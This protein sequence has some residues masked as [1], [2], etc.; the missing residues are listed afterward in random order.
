[1]RSGI[2]CALLFLPFYAGIIISAGPLLT[3][4][5]F[6]NGGQYLPSG[7]KAPDLLAAAKERLGSAISTS[8]PPGNFMASIVYL[9]CKLLMGTPLCRDE[10][11]LWRSISSSLDG[12]NY[13]AN[14][15]LGGKQA[16]CCYVR[17]SAVNYGFC[18]FKSLLSL[19]RDFEQ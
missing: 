15:G 2:V 13:C 12:S 1:M 11:E 18:T 10:T 14:F 9:Q 7:A 17:V 3:P 16:L 6:L 8:V 4:G 5:G 19:S